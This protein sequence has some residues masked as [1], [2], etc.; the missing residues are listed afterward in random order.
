MRW[1][2]GLL[3][4]L[5][6]TAGAAE[7]VPVCFNYGCQAQA[8]VE[9]SD[10]QLHELGALLGQAQDAAQERAAISVAIGR[11]LRWAGEQTPIG[12]D[13]GGNFADE[14]VSGRMDCIDHSTTTTRL[15][16][17]IE[18]HGGLRYH[19]VGEI[20]LRQRFL[21][22]EH[23]AAHIDE[24]TG[25]NE[26]AAQFAVDTWFFDNGQPA[27]IMPLEKWLAGEGPDGDE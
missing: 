15:L 23:Y 9:Y 24:I 2:G 26:A 21:V 18:R 25:G 12:A 16:R 6:L 13:R 10:E 14:G 7:K 3:L 27:V 5:V 1:L 11:M 20:V 17:L 8:V 4:L 19:R 22:F